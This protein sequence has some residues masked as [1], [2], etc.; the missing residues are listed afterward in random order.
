MEINDNLRPSNRRLEKTEPKPK[1][2]APEYLSSAARDLW[3]K[4]M[5]AYWID[6]AA[7]VVLETLCSGVDRRQQAR[8]RISADGPIVKDRFGVV[9]AHPALALERDATL[10]VQR[11]F[12]LL[13][14]DQEA[15][16]GGQ[17]DLPWDV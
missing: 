3:N 1:S 12:R 16:G 4:I 7:E 6:V 8:E 9:K 2:P 17:M 14:F 5:D 10:Q 15:R 13:G 11:A